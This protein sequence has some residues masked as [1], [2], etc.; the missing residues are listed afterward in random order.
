M[1]VQIIKSLE[2]F[3][4]KANVILNN[5]ILSAYCFGSATYE[6]FHSGYSDLDFFIITESIISE[7]DFQKFSL[8]RDGLKKAKHPYFSVLEGEIISRSAIKNDI[9]SNVIYW[10]T[11]KDRLKRKYGTSGFSLRGLINNGY[12]IYGKDLRNELPYPSN[13][14][15]LTQ[16][17][18]MIETIRKHAQITN[19]D[20]HSIDWLFLISQSIYWIKTSDIAG[21]TNAARWIVDSC[22]YDWIGTLEK[23]IEIRKSPTLANIDENKE[24]L[25]NLG[26]VIQCACDTLSV[27]KNEYI[28][29]KQYNFVPMNNEYANEIAYK[30]KYNGVYSFY[31]M[32]A[33]EEDLIEFLNEDSWDGHYFAVLNDKSELIGFYSFYFEEE[34]MWIGFGLKP[35]LTGRKLGADFVIAGIKF[36]MEKLNYKKS[37]IMLAVASFNK[38][39]INLYEKIGFQCVE[40]YMQKTNGGEFEFIKMKK[41]I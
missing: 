37:Y 2:E 26:D 17:N 39:A 24:W 40:K 34:I 14:E 1:E 20:V 12:L 29:T 23:A 18:S 16:V 7:D 5:S 38:R 8:W 6:D 41:Y 31:D 33:D 30:W 32:T 25:K 28:S 21:K 3:V 11:S 4:D 36:A 22:D 9:E 27:E 15:M 13:E 10:G 35:E 19:E